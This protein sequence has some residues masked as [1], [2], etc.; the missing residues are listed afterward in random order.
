MSVPSTDVADLVEKYR[1][2]VR[3]RRHEEVT[4]IAAMRALAKRHPGSLR[5]LD[6]LPM[7]TLEGKLAELEALR[8]GSAASP[9]PRWIEAQLRFHALVRGALVAKRYV[10]DG[11]APLTAAEHFKKWTD[12]PEAHAWAT[13]L[14][15]I[16]RPPRG[17]LLE[18]VFARLARELGTDAD[19]ARLLVFT[20]ER[21][22]R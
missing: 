6:E 17:R 3:L 2:I 12:D 18:L 5:E 14:A 9:A 4:P 19:E 22:R 10:R 16:R 7:E 13:E 21:P 20:T 15:A 8:D 1:A 11:S